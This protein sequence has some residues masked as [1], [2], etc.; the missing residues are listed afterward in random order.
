MLITFED[1]RYEIVDDYT[2]NIYKIEAPIRFTLRFPKEI[3]PA[4]EAIKKQIEEIKKLYGFVA[5]PRGS[6]EAT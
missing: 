2:H 5:P 1:L 6:R 4:P 3:A